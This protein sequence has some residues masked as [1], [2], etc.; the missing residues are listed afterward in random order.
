[1]A[2]AQY[3]ATLASWYGMAAPDRPLVFPN[4]GS[5][6]SATIGFMG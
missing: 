6:D 3:A 4:I 2:V 1:M 5:F